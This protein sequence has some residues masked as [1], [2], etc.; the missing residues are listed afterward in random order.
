MYGRTPLSWAAGNGHEAVVKLLLETDKVDV[1]SKDSEYGRTPLSWAAKNGHEA[2][3]KLLLETGKV[4]IDSKDKIWPDAVL[5]AARKGHEAVVKLLLE[6]DKVDID[7]KDSEYDQTPLSC[8]AE[9]GMRPSPNCCSRTTR[10]I[11]TQKTNM[12][13]RRSRGPLEE[14]A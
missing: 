12:A 7:S 5:V 1:D 14:W 3:V 11:S 13:E 2:V 6:T 4:D 9:E 8:A 10:S